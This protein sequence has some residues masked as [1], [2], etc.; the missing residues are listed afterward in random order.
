MVQRDII[1]G[2]AVFQLQ[3]R[4]LRCDLSLIQNHNAVCTGSLFHIVRRQKNGHV[5]FLLQD[6]NDIPDCLPC[7]RVQS[8]GWFVQN[9]QLRTVKD[10][11]GDVNAPPL[12]AGKLSHTLVSKATA[13]PADHPVQ[14]DA[15]EMP[16]R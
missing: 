6:R 7:L 9:Q 12:S 4:S 10:G 3:R 16:S 11:T 5:L 8:R 13:A 14:T 1:P 15:F 2:I